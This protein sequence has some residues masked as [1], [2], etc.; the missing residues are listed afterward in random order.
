M[1]A[2]LLGIQELDFTPRNGEAVQ[3]TKLFCAFPSTGVD[4]FMTESFFINENSDI[5]LPPN[6]TVNEQVALEFNHKGRL[7][8][9]RAVSA[10]Q[11]QA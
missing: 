2:K 5:K 8:G 3:G 11:A 4:G 9:L 6:L 10:T 1:K 7:V